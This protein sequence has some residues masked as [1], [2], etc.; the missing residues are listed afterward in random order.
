MNR[1][2]RGFGVA[3]VASVVLAATAGVARAD[4]VSNNLD[5]KV[6]ANLEVMD[7]NVSATG[8]VSFGVDPANLGLTSV[9]L[10]AEVTGAANVTIETFVVG[11]ST[12]VLLNGTTQITFAVTPMVLVD[13]RGTGAGWS[14]NLTATQFTNAA[15][16]NIDLQT[17]QAGSL[18]MGAVSIVADADATPT[19]NI[20]IRTGAIDVTGGVRIVNAPVNGGMG[21]YVISIA[22]M[23]LTLL[24]RE[25]KA[26]S[27]TSAITMTLSQGPVA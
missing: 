21:T 9:D 12:A 11:T 1:K 8:D 16:S 24:P 3:V 22:P 5:N 25:A 17:L 13:A 14:V 7:L 19:T 27:Y 10:T 2:L 15:A 4:T 26:G 6:D 20:G 23:T 18:V